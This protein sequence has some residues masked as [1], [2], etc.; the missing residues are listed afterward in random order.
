[1]KPT[2]KVRFWEIGVR[3]PN[4]K[5]RRK[6][7]YG[8][9]WVTDGHEHS[10]WFATKALAR[11]YLNKLVRAANQGEAFD[12]E[13]GLPESMYR[14]QNSPSLLRV[15]QEFLREIWPDV[16]P[17]SR[18]RLLDG[19]AVAVHGFLDDEIDADPADV[20]RALTS[21][22][23]PPESARV[24]GN[25]HLAGIAEWLEQ[26][27]R[28]VAELADEKETAR[29]GRKL[30]I[31]LDGSKAKVRTV[32]T[33][34]GSLVQALSFAV[35]QQYLSANPFS[36]WSPSRFQSE[37]AI[38]PGVVVNPAQAR[39]LLAAVTYA[40]PRSR[41]V[42]W[43]PFFATLYF[44]GT[45]PGE[46]RSLAVDNCHL[47][48]SGWGKLILPNSLGRSA[49][50]LSDDGE[51]Y[52]VRPLKHRPEEATREVPIPPELVRILSEHIEQQGV[53]ADGR[54]FRTAAGGPVPNASYTDIWRL[55]RLY[56]LAPIQV[57]SQLARRPYD[58]RHAAVSSW[59]AAGVPLP[60]VAR[61]AG[62]T[63]QILTSV[64]AKV[65]YG[66][67]DQMNQRIEDFLDDAD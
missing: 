67:A 13:T 58:L 12:M 42:S 49:A 9:R 60:E 38:D 27:S 32:G 54:L 47:P 53:A 23:L 26:H 57:A 22:V 66:S 46:A 7:S 24:E 37:V 6:A 35:D 31:K 5:G 40:R 48:S 2:Y 17:N 14:E 3:K 36:G 51:V 52:Q 4:E 28:K 16:S 1:M 11:S 34:R 10:E 20:R 64:Y 44:A 19:L 8:A 43:R 45:R 62:Q 41:N 25:G 50:R 29:L 18:G 39:S 33:R 15:A 21:L 61:R 63:V 55:A 59:I 56:G 65:I 30:L